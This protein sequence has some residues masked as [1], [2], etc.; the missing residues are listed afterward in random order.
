MNE[1]LLTLLLAALAELARRTPRARN[2]E[3]DAE[4]RRLRAE[5]PA[6]WPTKALAAR[7]KMKPA[8]VRQ[9]LSRGRT[10]KV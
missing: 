7:F 10:T 3:R 1:L 2:A 9:V 4:I 8:A 6:S 5:D